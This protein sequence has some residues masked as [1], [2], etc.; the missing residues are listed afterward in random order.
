LPP[1]IEMPPPSTQAFD[2]DEKE[3]EQE[4]ALMEVVPEMPAKI[5]NQEDKTIVVR[6]ILADQEQHILVLGGREAMS[7]PRKTQWVELR[8]TRILAA[9][10]QSRAYVRIEKSD[11]RTIEITDMGKKIPLA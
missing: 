9:H 2:K 11:G 6:T 5:I 3:K 10:K 8:P 7:L 4:K 1:D